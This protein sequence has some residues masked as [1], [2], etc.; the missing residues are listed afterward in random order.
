M[1]V[2]PAAGGQ[3]LEFEMG[4][5][6]EALRPLLMDV[7]AIVEDAD[8]GK[9]LAK[10]V[11]C[12]L[13]ELFVHRLVIGEPVDRILRVEAAGLH[14][15]DAGRADAV[16]R[17][18]DVEEQARRIVALHDLARLI[19]HVAAVGL[20][21]EADRVPAGAEILAAR[22]V[23]GKRVLELVGGAHHPPFGMLARGQ[24]VPLHR[25][26]DRRLDVGRLQRGEHVAE[27]IGTGEMRMR[28]ADLGR[29]VRPAVVALGEE[30]DR[31]DLRRLERRDEIV[32]I[33]GRL[34]TPPICSDVWK[35]RWI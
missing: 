34:P 24:F 18:H 28:L 16:G 15:R 11:R 4:I 27:Q 29:V 12:L 10:R 2:A 32:R 14:A 21:V 26:I 19:E 25:D 3:A 6:V 33:E 35:S 7:A 31:I 13:P 30:R 8:A 17:Q 22:L 1:V 23:A 20:V 9:L 5:V